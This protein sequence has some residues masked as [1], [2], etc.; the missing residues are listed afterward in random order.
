[1]EKILVVDDDINVLKVIKMRL[2]AEGYLVT[3]AGEA[4]TALKLAND[5]VFDFALVDLKLNGTNGIQLMENLHQLNPEMPVIILTAYGTI[6]SAVEAMRK[7]AYTYLTKP[8]NYD[9][10]LLQTRNCLEKTK[11]TK[12]VKS[13][14]KMVKDRYGFD[15]II[16]RSNKME[17]VLE[18]VAKA[19]D[20]D[21]TICIEGE[22]G[23][24][25]ELIARTLHLA[26]AR[27]D[28]QFVAI[29]CA[30]I[31]EMLFESEL[32]GYEKGAFTGAVQNKEGLFYQAQGG[33]F[34]LDEISEMPLSMQVK[35][36]RVM[37]EKEF[38][39]VGGRKTIKMD[40]RFIATSNKNLKEEM[41]QGNFREDLFYRIYVI[42]IQ[43]P[44]L[45]ERKGDIPVLSHYFLDKL[46]KDMNKKITGFSSTALQKLML[47][48]WPGNVRELQNTIES[49]VTM[50]NENIIGDDLILPA[51]NAEVMD[52]KP[53]KDAKENF[54]KNY[55]LQLI[56]LTEGN[57]AQ[58]ARLAGKYRADLYE[59]L[60]KYDLKP[61]NFRKKQ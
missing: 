53:L 41:T 38:I 13:L 5:D 15:D 59:L 27:A 43:L 3:T 7:G 42:D 26:S 4:K 21:S 45:R 58:A 55:L 33:T 34:F 6:K 22:S 24:G 57:M 49:A 12:E 61:S 35:L 11:L 54:E 19:A 18:Q 16:G 48:S 31:P 2:E 56:E 14:K 46:S 1:M 51:L 36:L 39:P 9:E 23:T 29:N 47:H 60:K 32:F 50:A 28:R 40:I 30:A 17:K 25:K 52:L 8:F 10:L 44:P 37:Q 20:S